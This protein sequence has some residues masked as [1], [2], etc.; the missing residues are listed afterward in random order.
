[1]TQEGSD[2]QLIDSGARSILELWTADNTKD[3]D[4]RFG[5]PRSHLL[6]RPSMSVSSDE[7][8]YLPIAC[9]HASKRI[10]FRM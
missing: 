8:A 1:M 7:T 5:I 3:T 4:G 2:I 6:E 10:G 9:F